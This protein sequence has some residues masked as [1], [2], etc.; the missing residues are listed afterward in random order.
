M[1]MSRKD[2][3]K[4]AEAFREQVVYAANDGRQLYR[5]SQLAK[6]MSDVFFKDNANFSSSTFLVACGFDSYGD[7]VKTPVPRRI[8]G[9][10][11]S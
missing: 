9:R 1:S 6:N 10:K 11:P 2:Y 4:I 8:V 3:R 5:L 7:P